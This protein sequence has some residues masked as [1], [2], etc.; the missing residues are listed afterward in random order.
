MEFSTNYESNTC[1]KCFDIYKKAWV[2]GI[3]NGNTLIQSILKQAGEYTNNLLKTAEERP[4][5]A[6][7]V[8][9]S[10]KRRG[11]SGLS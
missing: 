10:R 6:D 2:Y 7:F 11:N 9:Q 1:L 3:F 8:S 5:L 4:S